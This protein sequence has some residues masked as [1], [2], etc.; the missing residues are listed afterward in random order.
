MRPDKECT[1]IISLSDLD[2]Y[3]ASST[4]TDIIPFTDDYRMIS[5]YPSGVKDTP[6]TGMNVENEDSLKIN[7]MNVNVAIASAIT[8]Y[9]R[10]YLSYLE[11]D[12]GINVYNKDT[13]SLHVDRPLPN[14]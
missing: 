10:I 13:D 9:G 12:L 11:Y 4:I 7:H 8:S 6:D 5:Y 1:E 2:K 14:E 3:A